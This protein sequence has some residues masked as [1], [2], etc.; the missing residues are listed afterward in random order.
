M[1]NSFQIVIL[2]RGL[3]FAFFVVH[4]FGLWPFRFV[5]QNS[6]IKY[7]FIKAIH[8]ICLLFGG[9]IVYQVIGAMTFDGGNKA[10]F[11]SYTL[12]YVLL[13]YAQSVLLSFVFAY[14]GLHW[15]AKEI[16]NAYIKWM[17]LVNEMGDCLYNFDLSG[18]IWE[19]VL[20]TIVVEIIQGIGS[21]TYMTNSESTTEL[22]ATRPYLVFFLQLPPYVA[23]LQMNIFYGVVVAIHLFT[24]I[25]NFRLT[26]IVAEATETARYKHIQMC[27]YCHCSDE[28]DRLSTLYLKLAQATKSMNSIFSIPIVL[29]ST[30]I[31]VTL[32]VQLL[33][34]V[35]SVIELT[36]H[37]SKNALIFNV[38]GC[39]AIILS[40]FDQLSISNACQRINNS[41]SKASSIL[42]S[43]KISR[44]VDLRLRKSVCQYALNV[45]N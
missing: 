8:S 22:I 6:Q 26:N 11:G 40:T 33:N 36:L 2:R 38:Y 12:R 45:N 17:D 35:I 10:F 5:H 14:L 31:I 13:I 43:M 21:Y 1:D 37:L 25:V 29:W 4:F 16:E 7:S 9:I 19:F 41:T 20:R 3:K 34:Q 42:H 15:F 18:Y 28:L 23:R 39:L 30:T 32:T 24:R 44:D 27:N